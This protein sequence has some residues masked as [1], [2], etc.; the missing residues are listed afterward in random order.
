MSSF[1]SFADFQLRYEN[2]VPAA[3]EERVAVFLEDACALAEEIA[4]TSYEGVSGVP[5]TIVS[6]VCKA[7]RRAYEN[8]DGLQGET[9]GDYSWRMG[10]TGMANSENAGLYYTRSEERI[11]KRAAARATVGTLELEGMLPNSL[12]AGRYL[13]DSASPES[14]ILY[15]D[16]E[17]IP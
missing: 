14:P 13:A 2:T 12:D 16:H 17:D 11:L 9:I 6:V 7:V 1:V 4:D 5:T 15:F 8:P 10:Y 3:D